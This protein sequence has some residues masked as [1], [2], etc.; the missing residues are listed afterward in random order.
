MSKC[1]RYFLCKKFQR[2]YIYGESVERKITC[3][4]EVAPRLNPTINSSFDR[5]ILVTS[6]NYNS[7]YNDS[8]PNCS[9][10]TILPQ[11]KFHCCSYN[12][13]GAMTTSITCEF[14]TKFHKNSEKFR[15]IVV[16]ISS[17][18]RSSPSCREG[19]GPSEWLRV[20]SYH[21]S[22]ATAVPYF[23]LRIKYYKKNEKTRDH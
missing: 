1:I 9:L 17:Y 16:E 18:V 23:H 15:G 12:L 6:T 4:V 19:W 14:S 21:P 13:D 5:S 11:S 3:A 22:S 10:D 8:L 2:G 20:Q 7:I